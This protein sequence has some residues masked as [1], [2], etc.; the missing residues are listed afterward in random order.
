MTSTDRPHMHVRAC[1]SSITPREMS[2]IHRLL[3][4]RCHFVRSF[5]T[6]LPTWV[7]SSIRSV[8]GSGGSLSIIS[9]SAAK[10]PEARGPSESSLS[11]EG[12][13]NDAPSVRTYDRPIVDIWR[14]FAK[15]GVGV[16]VTVHQRNGTKR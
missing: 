14:R 3:N 8:S 15:G 6:P 1:S 11:G 13:A 9:A 16:G 2:P 5:P 4:S 12:G 7:H 10:P